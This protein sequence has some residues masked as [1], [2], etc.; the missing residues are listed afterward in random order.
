M[1]TLQ[2]I[3]RGATADGRSEVHKL[4]YGCSRARLWVDERIADRRMETWRGREEAD[5]ATLG[6]R[7]PAEGGRS[8]VTMIQANSRA[9]VSDGVVP[10]WKG[11]RACA[12]CPTLF[13]VGPMILGPKL[14]G[15]SRVLR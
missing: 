9:T 14:N 2:A 11:S 6:V 3:A 10:S 12:P 15:V 7:G 4:T 5:S 8:W 1:N 13:S